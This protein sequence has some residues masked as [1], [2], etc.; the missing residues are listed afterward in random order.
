MSTCK[1]PVG[2]ANTRISTGY[3]Q[4]NLPESPITYSRN[5]EMRI[6]IAYLGFYLD[7]FM[8]FPQ[9]MFENGQSHD[10]QQSYIGI[11]LGVFIYTLH[12][13]QLNVNAT[14]P[15][16][17]MFDQ[18]FRNQQEI[19]RPWTTNQLIQLLVN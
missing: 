3:A 17:G 19:F 14:S 15:N 2:L 7:G 9:Q 5:L 10:E 12:T 8:R 16:T 6:S 18:Y 13:R 4:K 11:K 1:Q